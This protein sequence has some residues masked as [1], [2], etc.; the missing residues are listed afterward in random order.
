MDLKVS[1]MMK[2]QQAL[3]DKHPEWGGLYPER[4][5]DQV[6]WGIGEIGEATDLI[7]KLGPERVKNDPEVRRAFIEEMGDVFM[8]LWDA[9]LCMGV[10]PEEF[11]DIY[12]AKCEKNL[13]RDWIREHTEKYGADED[14]RRFWGIEK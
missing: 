8:Y 7:K 1:D 9:L 3:Q 6:L 5:K 11:S 13:G 12:L 4:A 2:F 10:A 14:T